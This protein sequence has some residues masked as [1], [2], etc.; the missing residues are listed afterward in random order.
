MPDDFISQFMKFTEDSESPSSYFKWAAYFTL[1]ASL[2]DNVFIQQGLK[3]QTP[4]MYVL[5]H[6]DSGK[7]RKG[8]P[9]GL[10]ANILRG[11][12]NTKIITGRASIQAVIKRM[13]TP[14]MKETGGQITGGSIAMV[15]DELS[16]FFVYDPQVIPILT[17]MYDYKEIADHN[18][19][20][21]GLSIVKKQCV[22]FLMGSNEH[23]LREVYT[24]LAIH[25]G[26]L[27]RTFFIK[28]DVN[29]Q[30]NAAFGREDN[31]I[32]KD[33]KPLV[34]KLSNYIELK[35][36]INPTIE[37]REEYRKWYETLRRKVLSGEDRTGVLSR[38]HTGVIKL[39]MVLA[40]N[41]KCDLVIDTKHVEEAIE[42]CGNII[43]NYE[44]YS[45]A[46]GAAD[47]SKAGSMFLTAILA[48]D[49]RTLT[50][51]SFMLQYMWDVDA[52]IFEDLIN[53]LVM[54][55]MIEKN[56]MITLDEQYKL[57]EEGFKKL[58]DRMKMQ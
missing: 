5:L 25:G 41:E 26:L 17:D 56:I 51:K 23:M 58:K 2:R 33:P 31:E 20:G 44:V 6:G 7:Y 16:S 29:R 54:N 45:I 28:P 38:I 46:G 4:N 47:I 22:S 1:A 52:K 53:A 10:S 21:E 36:E 11:L 49:D 8:N 27:A 39:A 30:P 55:G 50:K 18:L 43:P 19:K 48:R 42:E 35:G 34:K 15:A 9:T 40:I 13:A 37:A 32:I 12:H 14:E 3:K 24:S 57:T